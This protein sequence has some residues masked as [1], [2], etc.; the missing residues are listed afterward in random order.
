MD[1]QLPF[2][3]FVATSFLCSLPRRGWFPSGFHILFNL[4]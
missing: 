2:F 4:R 3:D 1:L